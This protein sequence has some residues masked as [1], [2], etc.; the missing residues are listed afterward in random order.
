MKGI[1][2]EHNR[3]DQT[4]WSEA[5]C[6]QSPPSSPL[7]GGSPWTELGRFSQLQAEGIPLVQ[8]P[9]SSQ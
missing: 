7:H 2:T 1:Q 8:R 4:S 6:F 3:A 5:E 9:R